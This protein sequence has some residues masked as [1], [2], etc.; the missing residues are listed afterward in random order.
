M[1]YLQ[2]E[3]Y[4]HSCPEFEAETFHE[5]LWANDEQLTGNCYVKCRY[6]KRCRQIV[7]HLKKEKNE[8]TEHKEGHDT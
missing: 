8:N 5:R 1:I 3:D 4:C 7:S 2:V 6:Q